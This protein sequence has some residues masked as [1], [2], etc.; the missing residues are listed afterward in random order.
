MTDSKKATPNNALQTTAQAFEPKVKE[1]A[2]LLAQVKKTTAAVTSIDSIRTENEKKETELKANLQLALDEGDCDKMSK[3]N[4]QLKLVRAKLSENPVEK[5][6][7]FDESIDAL[8]GF[9][10]PS[11]KA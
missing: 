4:T 2:A 8:V 3:F 7:A 9:V 11:N 1:L 6:Q 5:L 10:M